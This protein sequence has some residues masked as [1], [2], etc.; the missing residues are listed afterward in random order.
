[1]KM[2]P[3]I[4]EERLTEA[5]AVSMSSKSIGRGSVIGAGKRLAATAI[6]KMIAT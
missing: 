1:M 4:T 3:S 2:H 6:A 5:V